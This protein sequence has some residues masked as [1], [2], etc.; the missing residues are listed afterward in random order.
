M[1]WMRMYGI[2]NKRNDARIKQLQEELSKKVDDLLKAKMEE[3]IKQIDSSNPDRALKI[4]NTIQRVV[5][6]MDNPPPEPVAVGYKGFNF[7]FQPS[8]ISVSVGHAPVAAYAVEQPGPEPPEPP[9]QEQ[10]QMVGEQGQ[11]DVPAPEMPVIQM[12]TRMS[13]RWIVD[14][15][16]PVV[17]E[18]FQP[19]HFNFGSGGNAPVP[20]AISPAPA[21]DLDLD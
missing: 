9:E 10:E 4:R 21:P 6:T 17:Q 13:S 20:D 1:F 14:E 8:D 12:T 11:M 15:P 16:E 3:F 18:H 7:K 19:M 5:E 2:S